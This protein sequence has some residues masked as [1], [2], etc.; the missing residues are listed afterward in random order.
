MK[1]DRSITNVAASVRQRLYNLSQK[2]REDFNLVL[3]RYAGERILYRLSLSPY[4]DSFVLKGAQLFSLWTATP[5]RTTRDLDL[6][7]IGDSTIPHL[8]NIF[9]EICVQPVDPSDGIEFMPDTVRGEE[10]REQAEYNGV[11][12]RVDYMISQAKDALQIDVGFGDTVFPEPE[13][14]EYGSLLDLPAPRLKA[15]PRESVIAEKFQ[16]MVMLGMANSRMKDFYDLFILASEFEFDGET[17]LKAVEATFE[18]RSTN[19]PSDNPLA[20]T[21]EFY[22]NPD[23]LNQWGAFLNRTGLNPADSDLTSVVQ[24]LRDFLMPPVIAKFKEQ[25][26]NKVWPPGGP[27]REKG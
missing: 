17:L 23:K 21:S 5:H 20:L 14:V 22:E 6:L 8:E 19:L 2:N 11:R 3:S 26:F 9:R 15:Y 24:L 4:A 27:W 16:A 10:I 18:Q 7:G 12:V 25:S 1:S 13:I